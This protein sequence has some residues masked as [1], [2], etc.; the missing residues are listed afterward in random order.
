MK[1][2]QLI[3]NLRLPQQG[4]DT[5]PADHPGHSQSPYVGVLK[6]FIHAESALDGANRS[7]DMRCPKPPGVVIG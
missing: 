7:A 6:R 4:A 3:K 1:N 5:H 2:N